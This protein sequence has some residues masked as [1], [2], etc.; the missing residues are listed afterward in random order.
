MEI[1][2]IHQLEK[3]AFKKSHSEI[4]RIGAALFFLAAVLV[5]S[6]M[7]SGGVPN[8]LFLAIAAVFGAYMAMNIGANDVANNVGPAVGSRAMTMGGAIVIAM[9]FEASGA[10][11]AGGDVV[12]TIKNGIVDI[13]GF[14]NNTEE[15]V[16]AMMAALL[17]AALWLN[18]ATFAGAPVSTTHS[19]VGGVMGAGIAAAGFSIVDWGTMGAIVS[20]WV[21]SPLLGGLIA[22]LFLFAI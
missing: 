12:S 16:W 22:A 6:F 14:G 18:L 21:I 3:Q 19:I 11:I 9:I 17:A 15:F 10:F 20:S 13:Q 8:N 4:A 2:T 7:T 1:K 5:F